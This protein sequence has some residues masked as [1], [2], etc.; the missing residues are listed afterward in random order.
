MTH[1]QPEHQNHDHEAVETHIAPQQYDEPVAQPVAASKGTPAWMLPAS[2]L[3]AAVLISG[4]LIY[5]VHGGKGT[6]A[7]PTDTT[8]QG[9]AVQ[10]TAPTAEDRD[11]ILGKADAPVSIVA[12]EDFQCP[13]CGQYF[14]E[15]ES[16]IRT[17]YVDTG[18]V[19][20]VYRHLAFL[21]P[22]SNAAAEA[23]ECAK[24]QGKF[25]DFHDA[26]FNAEI[27]DG[28]EG[29]GNLKRSLFMQLA[30][31]TKLNE[32]DFAKCIDSK[33]Y[34]DYVTQQTDDA[35]KKYGVQS[36]PT[37]FVNDQ[38]VEGA[39]PFATF[40]TLIDGFLNK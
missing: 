3:V 24:D 30:K 33:K 11:V 18:K 1:H 25:W 28:Q 6:T 2:I 12:Y 21:G 31:D 13:F 14:S 23:S 19:K 15:T 29:N 26:L 10:A 34:A 38:K 39:Y 37:I 17:A 9:G 4:S 5:L 16:Q 36:T 7:A 32:T 27:A 22:E 8:Q 35:H 40:Q 20:M